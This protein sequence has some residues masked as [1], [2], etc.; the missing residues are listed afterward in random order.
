MGADIW[1]GRPGQSLGYFRD[2][3]S[4]FN[5]LNALGMSYWVDLVP[6]LEKDGTFPLERNAWLL[7]ELRQRIALRLQAADGAEQARA[8][9]SSETIN[10]P[11]A[12]PAAM[13]R[14]W[15]DHI[16]Q[17]I[18]LLEESARIGVPLV[19]SL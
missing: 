11:Q 14:E 13:V 7:D 17:L 12:D 6:L 2:C 15:Y 19:M 9:L 5:T 4:P 18:R 16:Q 10:R 8:Y 1:L 3:Y